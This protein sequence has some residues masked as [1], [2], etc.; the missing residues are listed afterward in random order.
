[1]TGRPREERPGVG[2]RPPLLPRLLLR[3]IPRAHREVVT[4]DLEEEYATTV[5]PRRGRLSADLWFWRQVLSSLVA[6][7]WGRW[8]DHAVRRRPF[9]GVSAAGGPP[10]RTSGGPHQ[11]SAVLHDL[12]YAV[13]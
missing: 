13:H 2:D 1:M 7:A 6:T 5:R 4:G 3:L 12:A 11:P 8:R 10:V 9:R